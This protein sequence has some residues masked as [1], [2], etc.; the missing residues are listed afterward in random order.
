M[1]QDMLTPFLKEVGRL[2]GE[3]VETALE[4]STGMETPG[5][6]LIIL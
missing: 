3:G 5:R 4:G 2:L 6:R 1:I